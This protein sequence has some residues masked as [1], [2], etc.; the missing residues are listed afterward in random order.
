M[1]TEKKRQPLGEDELGKVSGGGIFNA[2]QVTTTPETP[3]EVIQDW[4]GE[5]AMRFATK[6]EAIAYAQEH[7]LGTDDTTW[8][9]VQLM[10]A[11]WRGELF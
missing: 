6:A 4:D 3:W 9:E 8:N 1:S 10:R 2:W 7:G 5:V 11:L